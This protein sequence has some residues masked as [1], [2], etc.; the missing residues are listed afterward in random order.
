MK[1]FFYF[2]TET[3]GLNPKTNDVIQIAAIPVIN[4]V[5]QTPFNEYCQPFDFNTVDQGTVDVHGI[6]ISKMRTFQSPLQLIEKLEEYVLSFNVKFTIAGY[7]CNFDKAMIGAMFLKAGKPELFRKLF[8]NDVHDVYGRAKS[9]KNQLNTSSLKLSAL[10]DEFKIPI[11]AHEALSDISATIDIDIKLAEMLGDTLI[12]TDHDDK[13]SETGLS[14]PAQL[15]IHSE[16]SNADS[17]SFIEDWTRLA[18]GK[19]IPALA[20]PDHGISASLFKASNP[21]VVFDKINKED[22]TSYKGKEV[23]FIPAISLNVIDGESYFRLNAWATSNKGYFNLVK[24][25]SVAWQNV[26]EDNKVDLPLI[27]IDDIKKYTQDVVF[28]TACEKGILNIDSIKLPNPID[29]L[30]W[31]ESELGRGKLIA[32]YLAY[33]VYKVFKGVAGFI[34]VGK[35]DNVPDGNLTSAIN[36]VLKRWVEETGNKAIISNAAHFVSKEEKILQDVISKSSYKD[37]RY[38]Y[39]SRHYRNIDECYS[40][41]KRHVPDFSIDDAKQCCNNAN[42]IGKLAS[43]I[44]IKHEFSLPTITIPKDIKEQSDNYDTQTYLYAMKK[45]KE[46]GRWKDDPIY[47][48]RFKKEIDVILKNKTLNFLPYFLM[49]EDIGSF[50]RQNGILQGLA[51]GSAGGSLLSYYLKIIHLDPVEHNLPFE[52]F[53]QL[54]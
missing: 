40:I 44:E 42:E 20:F 36:T 33:D 17:V 3:T 54:V 49:Y 34:S 22:K 52:R 2:D 43:N 13:V 47:V 18:I 29:R 10:A 38:F 30:R 48:A 28:G 6:S 15:H 37:G 51:R 50:A 27:S 8:D 16:Y 5:K 12:E 1:A 31:L 26:K 21:K 19:G 4:G 9:I 7:N 39:E 45:I 53:S 35:S 32:E 23:T 24:L 46:H 41:L 14:E 11:N 25:S